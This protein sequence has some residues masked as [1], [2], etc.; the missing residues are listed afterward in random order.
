MLVF[1]ASDV[2]SILTCST[3]VA[4]LLFLGFLRFLSVSLQKKSDSVINMKNKGVDMLK[5][6]QSR[7]KSCAVIYLA[8]FIETVWAFM[9]AVVVTVTG[10]G[11]GN[12][13]L[14][15]NISSLR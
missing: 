4:P 7:G 5:N 2:S 10:I 13:P 3:M 8:C 1:L 15:K 9:V 11:Q 14:A 6:T 12:L